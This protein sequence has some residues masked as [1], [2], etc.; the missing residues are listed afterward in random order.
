MVHILFIY[1]SVTVDIFDKS[2]Q[3]AKL[4]LKNGQKFDLFTGE[5]YFINMFITVEC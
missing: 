2:A 3:R 5:L 4:G 1:F